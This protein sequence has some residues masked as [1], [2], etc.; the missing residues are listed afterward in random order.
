VA[1]QQ[2]KELFY[3]VLYV[4]TTLYLESFKADDFKNQGFSK[5]IKSQQPQIVIRLLVTRSGFPL[6]YKVFSG[7]TFEGKTMLH[8]VEAFMSAHPQTKPIIVAD[9]AMLDEERL[10][11]L[12]QKGLSYIVGVRLASVV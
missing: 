1:Q 4:V 8:V 9:A 3:F 6:S 11:E 10:S 2:F 5:D 12:S 7:N